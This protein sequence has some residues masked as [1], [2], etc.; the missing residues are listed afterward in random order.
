MFQRGLIEVHRELTNDG[1]N[2]Q[3]DMTEGSSRGSKV[4]HYTFTHPELDDDTFLITLKYP[5]ATESGEFE[6][7]AGNSTPQ[8]Y[9]SEEKAQYALLETCRQV[10]MSGPEN[11]T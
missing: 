2:F 8:I 5:V 11:A 9:P 10:V 7:V 4:I 6:L 3:V 1:W